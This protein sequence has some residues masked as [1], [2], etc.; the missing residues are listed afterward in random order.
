MVRAE[1]IAIPTTDG[2][3]L[4]AVLLAPNATPRAQI[5]IHGA[6]AV[7]QSYYRPWATHLAERGAAVLTYDYRG[8]GRSVRGSVAHEPVTM[9]GWIDDARHVQR[10]ARARASGAP[11]VAVGHSFGGQI[12]CALQPAADAIVTIGAQGGYVGRFARPQRHLLE[13]YM[14]GFIPAMTAMFGRLPGWAGLGEDLP[15]GVA[16]QWARWCSHPEYMLSELPHLRDDLAAWSGPLFAL[17]FDDDS[18]AALPNVKWL[19]D[20]FEGASIEHE[21][22][23][24]ADLELSEVGHFGFFRRS[25]RAELWPRVDRFLAR[26]GI[27]APIVTEAERVL[28]DLQYGV[29]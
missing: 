12:A 13:L 2:R 18:Y 29:G 15:P 27:A 26:L 19:L 1:D 6:T 23:E 8:I 28:A 4:G 16:K 24:V 3:S 7:P 21:H 10:W 17:S 11:L 5:V 9:S 22:V 25:G 14:R 20:R